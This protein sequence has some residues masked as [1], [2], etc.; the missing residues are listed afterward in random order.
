MA[1]NE[2][3]K[4]IGK[5]LALVILIAI[6]AAVVITLVQELV[7]GHSYVAVTGGVVGA[8]VAAVAFN[9]MKKKS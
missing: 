3:Q 6:G 4:S 7:L 2:N 8:L 1:G 5:A 9:T